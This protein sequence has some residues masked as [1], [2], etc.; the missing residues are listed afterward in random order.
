MGP[1]GS[2][3]RQCGCTAV[4][5]SRQGA[6]AKDRRRKKEGKTRKRPEAPGLIRLIFPARSPPSASP[7]PPHTRD[8]SKDWDTAWY[9]PVEA[10]QSA[11]L[12]F[13]PMTLAL[14]QMFNYEVWS[15]FLGDDWY[16]N[17]VV[18]DADGADD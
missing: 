14:R 11:S 6:G 2:D 10:E 7:P 16:D 9:K 15:H 12:S 4:G 18:D 3:G 5:G 8:S 13:P 17:C 1:V